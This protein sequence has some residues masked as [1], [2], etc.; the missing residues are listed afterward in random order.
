[1]VTTQNESQDNAAAY[2]AGVN[3]IVLKPFTTQ[4]L[5]AA[6]DGALQKVTN[7]DR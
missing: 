3:D 1:M 7:K 2:K 6:I 4:S 5:G